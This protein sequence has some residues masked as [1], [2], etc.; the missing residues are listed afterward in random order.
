M[1]PKEAMP[2]A[3]DATKKAL[4]IDDQLAEAHTSMAKI[5]LS[6]EWDW[7]SAESEFK[8][9]IELN[10]GYATTHQWYGVY[11]SEMGR[12]DESMTE[13]KRAQELDPLS[14]PIST[15]V[16][17]ALFW[18]RR[19]DE[20]LN[21]LRKTLD[22][23]PKYADTHWSLGLAY[24]QKRMYP[25]AI[26]AFQKAVEYSISADFAGGKPEMVAALAHA[27]AVAGNQVEAG[28]ILRDLTDRPE[29]KRYISPYQDRDE[30][31]I[32]LRVDPRL[33]N[34]RADPQFV[35]RLRRINLA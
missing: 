8:R 20:A 35:E 3:L 10:P 5:K 30:S 28:K 24:E 32:H 22:K 11:L 15:G 17:R 25:E 18:A 26:A 9:A 33:D 7:A 16:G 23:D 4:A 13:R 19:Y 31:F 6:F 2:I 12:H 34:L 29:Q 14:L 1:P 27:Y 21:Q